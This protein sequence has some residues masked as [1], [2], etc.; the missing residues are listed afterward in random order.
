[1]IPE[2]KGLEIT[3][4]NGIR[5]EIKRISNENAETFSSLLEEIVVKYY[6]EDG[7]TLQ[8]IINSDI[9]SL[10]EATCALIPVKKI[11]SK[12]NSDVEYL[13]WDQ[14]KDNLELVT[15]LF[16]NSGLNS[17]REAT[18]VKAPLLTKLNFLSA[19]KWIQKGMDLAKESL[20]D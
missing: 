9:N 10:F 14:I 3:Y 19:T 20:E 4:S 13:D 7:A 1:M 12:K 17:D 11:G 8:M 5:Y 18:P 15:I 16:C 6:A 2:F